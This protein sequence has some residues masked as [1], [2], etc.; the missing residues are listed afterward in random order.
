M[1]THGIASKVGTKVLLKKKGS[2]VEEPKEAFGL[3]SQYLLHRPDKLVFVDEVGSNTSTDGHVGGEEFLYEAYGRPQ[4][5]AATKDSHFMVL[6]FTSATGEPIMCAIIFAAQPMCETWIMG[7]NAS[8]TWIG[9]DDDIRSNTAG[10]DKQ[11]PQGAVRHVNGKTVPTFC[12]CSENGSI[13][14]EILVDMLC[15]INS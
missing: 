11:Y 3:P 4:I 7:F 12:C 6:G 10:L 5:K 1:V 2:I 8:A 9:E 13:T 14:S 15:V